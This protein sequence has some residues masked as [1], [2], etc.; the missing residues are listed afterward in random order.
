MATAE[1]STLVEEPF[2]VDLLQTSAAA[3]KEMLALLDTFFTD[4]ASDD[5]DE[6]NAQALSLTESQRKLYSHIA[7]LRSQNRRL[8]HAVRNTK[9]QTGA[10]RAEVDRLHLSLQNLY[11]EQRHLTGEIDACENFEH[12]Y[13]KLPLIPLQD[14][15]VRFP[16]WLDEGRVDEE[17]EG[18]GEVELMR[19]R[20][21]EEHRERTELEE[22]R[23]E[24]LKRKMELERANVKRKE[25]L[26][27]L[28]SD[29]ETFMNEKA[30]MQVWALPSNPLAGFLFKIGPCDLGVRTST[31]LRNETFRVFLKEARI[32]ALLS[33]LRC[34]WAW[35]SELPGGYPVGGAANDMANSAEKKRHFIAD[36][37]DFAF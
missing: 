3:K 16:E 37:S 10:S 11:Y 35:S 19:A 31:N 6:L 14:F 12:T 30:S 32:A 22:K 24:L 1:L 2:L 26:S 4:P 33:A 13:S 28:D 25:K 18:A 17:G 15:F 36:K 9:A 20:I 8:A 21:E 5:P 34:K 27:K 7:L 29:L 23:K